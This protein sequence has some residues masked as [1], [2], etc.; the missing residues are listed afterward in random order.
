[1]RTGVWFVIAGAAV[2]AGEAEGL[3]TAGNGMALGRAGGEG[4]GRGVALG[5]GCG[6]GT[7]CA[8]RRQGGAAPPRVGAGA[9]DTSRRGPV[10]RGTGGVGKRRTA[11]RG[12]PA[13]PPPAATAVASTLRRVGP[14]AGLFN[15]PIPSPP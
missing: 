2:A 7:V 13:T 15:A 3:A 14:F 10:P 6:A 11:G 12:A 5:L 9:R 1:M 8:R 4:I